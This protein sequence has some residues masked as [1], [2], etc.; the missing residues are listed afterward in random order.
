M[1]TNRFDG[2]SPQIYDWN[3][4]DK[5]LE[6]QSK[7]GNDIASKKQYVNDITAIEVVERKNKQSFNTVRRDILAQLGSARRRFLIAW[8]PYHDNTDCVGCVVGWL[9]YTQ[10]QATYPV[11]ARIIGVTVH[12]DY[13]GVQI[14]KQLLR[15]LQRFGYAHL[16]AQVPRESREFFNHC[17]FNPFEKNSSETSIYFDMYR[18]TNPKKS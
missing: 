5:E 8:M 15:M 11:E 2:L 9:E 18:W 10:V 12:H 7:S 16:I 1:S 14:G 6:I 17:G 4:A 13:R 3:V